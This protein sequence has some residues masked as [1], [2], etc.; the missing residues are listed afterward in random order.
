MCKHKPYLDIKHV[1]KHITSKGTVCICKRCGKTI[2]PKQPVAFRIMT[3]PIVVLGIRLIAF[4][5][6]DSLQKVPVLLKIALVALASVVFSYVVVIGAFAITK[7]VLMDIKQSDYY[8][9]QNDS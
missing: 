2:V 8:H 5:I 7:W 1:L 6:F 4:A 3:I 9:P